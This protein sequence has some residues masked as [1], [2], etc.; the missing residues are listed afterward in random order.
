[1]LVGYAACETETATGDPQTF[2]VESFLVSALAGGGGSEESESSLNEVTG[3]G[4][5]VGGGTWNTADGDYS[6]IGG[7]GGE[8]TDGNHLGNYADSDYAFIGAG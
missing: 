7:G 1:M 6:F 2:S 5:A 8:D 3:F 4:A